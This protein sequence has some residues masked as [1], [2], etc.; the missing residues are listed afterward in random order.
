[1][2]N[3]PLIT[4]LIFS[5]LMSGFMALFMSAWVTFI[6][7]GMNQHYLFNWIRAFLLAWPAGFTVVLFIAPI[8]QKLTQKLVLILKIKD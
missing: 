6:N 2:L 7:M 8:A 1:M 5:F 3:K 4:K